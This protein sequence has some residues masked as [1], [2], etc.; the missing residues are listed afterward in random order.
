MNLAP[1]QWLQLKQSTRQAL[2]KIFN[3]P[4]STFTH[5]VDNKLE[6]DGHTYEDLKAISLEEMKLLTHSPS[7]NFWEQF[8]LIVKMVEG[9]VTE[10]I[11]NA[12]AGNNI[13]AGAE[14]ATLNEPASTQAAGTDAGTKEGAKPQET[15]S[16]DQVLPVSGGEQQVSGGRDELLPNSLSNDRAG[17]ATEK[18]ESGSQQPKTGKTGGLKPR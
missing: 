6:S 17:M 12:P 1:Q 9:G 7:D 16:Q 14:N 18:K 8:E 11:N 15:V 4:Q 5:V 10:L 2:V 3:I 13:P